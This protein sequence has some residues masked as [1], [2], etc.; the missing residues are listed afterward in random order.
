MS[1]TVA[2]VLARELTAA[3]VRLAFTVPGESF[4]PALG[5][6]EEAGV[7]VIATRHEGGA[8]FMAEAAS[9]LLG[10][11]QVCLGTRA[12]GAANLSIG[13]HTARQNSTPMVAIVGQV[14]RAH[15]GREAFQE[16]DQVASFGRLAK[17]AAEID[18]PRRATDLIREGLRQA[19]S[20]R[21]GPVLI[22]VPEDVW[23]LDAPADAEV[24]SSP[25][26][27]PAPV[28][29]DVAAVVELLGS[30]VRPAIV[31]GGGLLRARAT[32]ALV[33]LA[34]ALAVPVVAAWRRPDVFPNDH[35]LYL[36][37]TGYAAAPTVLPR[38]LEADALVVIGCRLS[39]VAAFEYRIPAE[40]CRW[41]HVDLEPR[42]AIAG[43]TSPEVA[44][45]ADAGAFLG[46]ALSGVT[47]DPAGRDRRLAQAH[48]DRRAYVEARIVDRDSWNG[49]GVHPGRVISTLQRL[50]PPDAILTTDAGNFSGWAARGYVWTHPGTFLGPTS[51]AMG[52]GLP[53]AIAASLVH[54]DRPVVALCGDG[55]FAMTMSELETG[56]REGAR[57]IT[58]VFDNGRYGTIAMHQAREGE[59]SVATDLGRIDF[60]A[61][62][63]ASGALGL[64]VTTDDMLEPALRKALAADRPSV[65]HVALDR[66]WLSVD[67]RG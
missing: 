44:I 1:D 49:P 18:D 45:P 2:R 19:M 62:A 25:E 53:A 52:Y 10:V 15:R 21:P 34:E 40:G 26:A 60:A 61:V 31:A 65:L 17:A 4:L 6:L 28:P 5:A 33:E 48:A 43:L 58:L 20:G 30:A 57:P 16:V 67:A 36:G 12:V 51:G 55:G 50:L 39:E 64:R 24:G 23:A 3:G 9:Q 27:P 41:A 11:P 35:S 63:E 7:R 22:S 46:A 42:P 29:S 37:M 66:S 13:I 8:A 47:V 32:E 59:P 54:P 38:L 14:K 56:V